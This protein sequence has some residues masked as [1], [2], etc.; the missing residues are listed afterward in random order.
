MKY[1]LLSDI[2]I[3]GEKF[4]RPKQSNYKPTELMIF[5]RPRIIDPTIDPS[6]VNTDLIDARV[7]RDYKPVFTSPSGKILNDA[8]Q[9]KGEMKPLKKDLPSTKVEL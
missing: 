4:F 3:L 1:N 2:P 5:L 9:D 6:S 7:S 8:N